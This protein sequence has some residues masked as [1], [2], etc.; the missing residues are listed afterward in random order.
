MIKVD[1]YTLENVQV[2][3]CETQIWLC[4][5]VTPRRLHDI[6]NWSLQT[7]F[8]DILNARLFVFTLKK[9]IENLNYI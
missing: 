9:F 3:N 8:I 6:I 1:Y 4:I 7:D 5:I 2:A